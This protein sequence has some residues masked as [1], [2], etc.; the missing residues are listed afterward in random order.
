[1]RTLVDADI[2][3]YRCAA[4]SENEPVDIATMRVD[5]LMR[6]IL[7]DTGATE[8][9]A[10]LSGGD[11][12]RKKLDASYKANRTKEAPRWL[13]TCREHLLVHWQAKVVSQIEADDIIG[14]QA[15]AAFKDDLPFVVASIDKDLKQLCGKHYNFVKNEWDYVTPLD[16]TKLFY[17][18]LLVGDRA[19]NVTGV[20]GIGEVKAKRAIDCLTEEIDMFNT[21]YSLYSDKERFFTNSQLLW[22]LKHSEAQTEILSHFLSLPLH[23]EAAKLLSSHISRVMPDPGLEPIA[24]MTMTVASTSGCP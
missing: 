18:Q 9:E 21:V 17:R 16:G 12:F 6:R 14:I 24:P 10:Y 15:T 8:Y 11:S 20:A 5:E 7:H 1:M 23:D 19:D 2:V 22:I 4:A 13:E 3:T